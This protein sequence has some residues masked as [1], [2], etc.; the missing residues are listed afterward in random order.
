MRKSMGKSS[1]VPDFHHS[2]LRPMPAPVGESMPEAVAIAPI[3]RHES[4]SE[5]GN[6]FDQ[7]STDGV[8]VRL[9]SYTIGVTANRSISTRVWLSNAVSISGRLRSNKAHRS[10]AEMF[11]VL[12]NTSFQG[13]SWSRCE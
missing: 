8:M 3:G 12:T 6:R 2:S 7:I 4:G 10:P 9:Q 5:S 11:P 1:A 13:R